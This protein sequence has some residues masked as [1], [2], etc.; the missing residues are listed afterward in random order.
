MT[1][2]YEQPLPILVMGVILV[3]ALT[4]GFIKTGQRWLIGATAVVILLLIVL[5]ALS[6]NVVTDREQV[7]QTIRQIAEAVE[8]NNID[9]ALR[10]VSPAAPGVQHANAE[11]RRIR[12]EEVDV[13]RN[14]EVEVFPDRNPPEAEAR[15]NVVVVADV[16]LGMRHYPRYV[17]A[18]FVKEGG[19]WLVIDYHHDEPTRSMR[20]DRN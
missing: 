15:F 20:I 12:F 10:H 4:A 11:L 9:E 3:V 5:I 13:K 19:R 7:E 14:L 2:L 1:W 6:R 18:T 16:G 17:E 8:Q